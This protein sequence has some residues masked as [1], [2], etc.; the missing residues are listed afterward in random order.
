MLAPASRPSGLVLRHEA[1]VGALPPAAELRTPLWWTGAE[2]ALLRGTN[3]LGGVLDRE[4]EWRAEWEAVKR[5][6]EGLEALS[7]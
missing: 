4:A 1:Y 7:W 3:L 6:L 5:D 2:R